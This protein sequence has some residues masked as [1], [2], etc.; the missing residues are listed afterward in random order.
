MSG[1]EKF[2]V[3]VTNPKGFGF[4]RKDSHKDHERERKGV[5]YTEGIQEATSS[6]KLTRSLNAP[7]YA[8][9]LSKAAT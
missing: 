5:L 6:M 4:T 7:R 2:L 8:Y 1:G 9:A 3:T